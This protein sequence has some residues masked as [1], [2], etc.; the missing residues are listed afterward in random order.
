[1]PWNDFKAALNAARERPSRRRKCGQAIRDAIKEGPE[2]VNATAPAAR[3]LQVLPDADVR[4]LISA[5][6]DVDAEGG[7]EGDLAR[8]V[9]V[10]AATGARFS[11]VIGSRSGTYKP[12]LSRLM[13]PTSRKGRGVKQKTHTA[14]RVGEDV[15]AGA[16]EGDGRPEG[17]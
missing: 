11:Q 2:A 8:I 13:V 12:P 15:L 1:M 3:E 17:S 6:W 9:L 7:W 5:A 16:S 10:L 14:I 4:G